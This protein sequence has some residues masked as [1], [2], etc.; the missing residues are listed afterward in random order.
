MMTGGPKRT[1]PCPRA[2]SEFR[3]QK[4]R[5]GTL[6]SH[7][8]ILLSQG[9][10]HR[11]WGAGVGLSIKLELS[12]MASACARG[13]LGIS[14]CLETFSTAGMTQMPPSQPGEG[15]RCSGLWESRAGSA[16][17]ERGG[18]SPVHNSRKQGAEGREEPAGHTS[19]STPVC[20][21][22]A[23]G[24]TGWPQRGLGSRLSAESQLLGEGVA[25][26]DT[27]QKTDSHALL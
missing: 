16:S 4:G 11:G 15:C 9:H 22:G 1:V 21:A 3:G 25:M 12:T 18:G 24:C 10:C 26:E 2:H 14:P 7:P 20:R 5:T 8:C 23:P 17:G 13:S 27:D 6:R 19:S